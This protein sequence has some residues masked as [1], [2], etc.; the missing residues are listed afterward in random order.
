M[1]V[2]VENLWDG[3]RKVFE[4]LDTGK[5][6]EEISEILGW[7]IAV[8]QRISRSRMGLRKRGIEEVVGS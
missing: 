3:H 8:V 5:A 4:L 7:D 6:E 2:R 1:N